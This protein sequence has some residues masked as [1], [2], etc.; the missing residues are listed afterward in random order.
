[1][2]DVN[3][4]G[5]E[6][7][8]N[9]CSS[10]GSTRGSS[11]FFMWLRR[12]LRFRHWGESH[13]WED[14]C[15]QPSR[16]V[17]PVDSWPLASR[18]KEK[19]TFRRSHY[20]CSIHVW[21]CLCE[22]TALFWQAWECTT[23]TTLRMWVLLARLG[24]GTHQL[25]GSCASLSELPLSLSSWIITG[26]PK[27]KHINENPLKRDHVQRIFHLPSINFQG[28]WKSEQLFS[29]TSKLTLPANIGC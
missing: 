28:I 3:C 21:L 2:D 22:T 20:P 25:E 16:N 24:S 23:A 12:C 9:E 4:T 1:M 14:G 26:S 17:G 7:S 5:T 6:V 19:K 11:Y 13:S 29:V 15:D 27:Q 10:R 8:I 18:S